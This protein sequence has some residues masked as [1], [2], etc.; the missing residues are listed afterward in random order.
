MQSEFRIQL[1][2]IEVE[3][4]IE[5]FTARFLSKNRQIVLHI[6][7]G[8]FNEEREGNVID[9]YKTISNNNDLIKTNYEKIC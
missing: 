2:K 3:C 8:I 6:D 7:M 4:Y 5:V 9:V 1:K